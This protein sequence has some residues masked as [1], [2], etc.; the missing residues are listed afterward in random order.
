MIIVTPVLIAARNEAGYISQTLE[1]LSHQLQAVQPIVIVNG[2]SDKTAEVARKS[3]VIVIE[4]REGKLPAI[5]AGL[6]YL[7]ER[8]LE[9]VLILDADSRP[10][11]K[12]WSK[13]MT[14]QLLSLPTQKPVIIWGQYVYRGDINLLLAPIF[15][16]ARIRV[17]WT[18]RH[19]TRPRLIRGGNVGLY[20]KKPQLLKEILAIENY[21]PRDD[22]AIYDSVK[23]NG[24]CHKV[25]FSPTGWILTSGRRI[26]ST[27]S[28]L[29]KDHRHSSIVMDTTY[30][31]DAPANSQPY[32]SKTTDTMPHIK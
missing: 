3:G 19:K 25:T 2:S 32:H 5:Q 9:P 21:W 16:L 27:M 30:N 20:I 18:D 17:A 22:V 26:T 1:T 12:R 31:D 15:T 6:R 7:K 24:G 29:L 4:S 10:L 14:A 8:A 11:S 23:R 13:Y 28:S